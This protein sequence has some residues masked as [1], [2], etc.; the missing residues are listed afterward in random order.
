MKF[1]S[2]QEKD[3]P[4]SRRE[5]SLASQGKDEPRLRWGGWIPRDPPT[6]PESG[7]RRSGGDGNEA[8]E[9]ARSPGRGHE[10]RGE[11]LNERRSCKQ[12]TPYQE[13]GEE[14]PYSPP[15]PGSYDTDP[16]PKKI[17]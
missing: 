9:G 11:N 3:E 16:P 7:D 4:R 8:R 13:P 5:Y 2:L 17:F 6:Y 15:Y 12:G 14:S 10:G 1:L